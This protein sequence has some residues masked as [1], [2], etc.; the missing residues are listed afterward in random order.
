MASQS[1][2]PA[3][4]AQA[5]G[6]TIVFFGPSITAPEVSGLVVATHAPPVRRGDLA[7]LDD[8]YEVIVILDGE[9]GQNL[10]VSPKEILAVLGRGRT[11]IGASSMGA[12]RASELDRYG[13]IGVG[14]VYDRFRTS[15]VRNDADVALVYSPFD[16]KPMTVPMVDLEYWLEM[17][18]AAGLIGRSERAGLLK[19]A[20][21]IFFAD[22]TTDRL[23]EALRGTV[24][25][26]TL[27]ALLAHSGGA[28]PSVK[29]IDAV[30]A[31]RLATS[32]RHVA[33]GVAPGIA[34]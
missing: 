1:P 34:R 2:P 4:E 7:A 14:W 29:S 16:C 3:A 25:G 31:L 19:A 21:S 13:M 30:A 32:S 10:S 27:D 5:P 6:R 33:G 15:A 12:L 23:M 9:F 8:D 22:R 20:R 26:D 18:C 24:G 28:I 11:V 17:A